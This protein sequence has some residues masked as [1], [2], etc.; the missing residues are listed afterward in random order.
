MTDGD[1]NDRL[2]ESLYGT[3]KI[4]PDE[5]RKYLGTFRERVALTLDQGEAQQPQFID[6]LHKELDQNPEYQLLINGNASQTA[7]DKLTDLSNMI[8]NPSKLLA[9]K[10]APNGMDALAAVVCTKDTALHLD[11]VDVA[12]R[13]PQQE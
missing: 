4:K 5:Q 10:A 13:F 12:K 3:P 9:G 6:V 1:L 11:E 8:S 7:V 2:S